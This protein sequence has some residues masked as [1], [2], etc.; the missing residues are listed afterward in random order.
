MIELSTTSNGSG[1]GNGGGGGGKKGKMKG[2]NKKKGRGKNK[3]GGLEAV[4]EQRAAK[5]AANAAATDGGEPLDVDKAVAAGAEGRDDE[6]PSA[7]AG[8]A[9]NNGNGNNNNDERTRRNIGDYAERMAISNNVNGVAANASIEVTAT[10]D[11]NNNGRLETIE[12]PQLTAHAVLSNASSL[13]PPSSVAASSAANNNNLRSNRSG[14]TSSQYSA[15]GSVQSSEASSTYDSKLSKG[16]DDQSSSHNSYSTYDYSRDENDPRNIDNKN[17]DTYS[18]SQVSNGGAGD[19]EMLYNTGNM[20]SIYI[21]DRDQSSVDESVSVFA[22]SGEHYD[23]HYEHHQRDP[24]IMD[25]LNLNNVMV[26]VDQ[27]LFP[28]EVL[29]RTRDGKGGAGGLKGRKR[30]NTTDTDDSESKAGDDS[31]VPSLA[32]D[33]LAQDNDSIAISAGNVSALDMGGL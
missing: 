25:V 15:N 29:E 11:V 12:Q 9:S 4:D 14:A 23:H 33:S 21:A 7:A 22:S 10:D 30:S 32:Q 18:Q 31:L 3:G 27:A 2:K 16:E 1:S 19:Y 5:S 26:A 28:V 6:D 13:A 17:S 24:N 20:P 8:A